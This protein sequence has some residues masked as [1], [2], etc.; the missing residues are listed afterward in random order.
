MSNSLLHRVL[1]LD[2]RSSRF[3]YV[4][5]EGPDAMLDWGTR[6]YGADKHLLKRVLHHLH[7]L[8]MPSVILVRK[9]VA[10]DEK[11]RRKIRSAYR[12]LKTFGKRV[13]VSVHSV[14]EPSR[15]RF[16]FSEGKLNKHDIAR[17]VSDRFPELS[18]RLPPKRKPWQSEPTR[19]SI[20]DAASLGFFYFEQHAAD[21]QQPI[22]GDS[23]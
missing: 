23:G 21:V 11:D 4:V 3:G 10:R 14:N 18:W 13:F 9:A 1:A 12:I 7:S 22:T 5:Y 2:L 20:F 8:L 19:Q 15:R 16:F 17:M 6:K